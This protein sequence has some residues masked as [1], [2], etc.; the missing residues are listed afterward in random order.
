MYLKGR[1]STDPACRRA[2]PRARL[3][4]DAPDL[5]AAQRNELGREAGC[6]A[7]RPGARQVSRRPVAVAAGGCPLP[8]RQDLAVEVVELSDEAGDRG[9]SPAVVSSGGGIAVRRR[10]LLRGPHQCLD[11]AIAHL[12]PAKQGL[13]GLVG[14]IGPPR[15][16][17]RLGAQMRGQPRVRDGHGSDLADTRGKFSQR[18]VAA[19]PQH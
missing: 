10:C 16:L 8:R 18:C 6:A 14:D 13:R 1:R 4:P 5:R 17:L 3:P 15:T 12:R 2:R 9:L 11:G 19:S 7:L